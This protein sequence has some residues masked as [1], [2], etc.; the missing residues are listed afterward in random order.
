MRRIM[1]RMAV[2]KM[3]FAIAC[4]LYKLEI[5]GA[6]PNYIAAWRRRRGL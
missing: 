4:E 2:E 3:P 1:E 6:D 5:A